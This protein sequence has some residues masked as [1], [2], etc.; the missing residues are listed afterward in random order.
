[1]GQSI[2][3]QSTKDKQPQT[4]F[5]TIFAF[6][7]N[8]ETLGGTAYLI[9]E[10][11]APWVQ[12]TD[13]EAD[14]GGHKGAN[15]LVDCPALTDFHREF[16]HSKGGI[17]TLFITH[18]GG[19]A[20]VKEFQREFNAQ[21]LIQEQEAYLLPGVE[22]VVFHRD[23]TLSSTSK[24]IWNPGHSPGSASLYYSNYGGVLFT[25]RHLVPDRNGAP[26]PLRLSKTFHWPRQL[27]YAQQLLSDFTADDLSYICP[28]A[29]TG[30]LRGD[31]TIK[32]AYQQL[33]S[34]NWQALAAAKP[35]I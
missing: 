35:V 27:R 19:M 26:V 11:L 16:I 9:L 29:S 12:T 32:A 5:D 20:R 34:T 25:G 15:I 10:D 22:T 18:R 6:A 33:E 1:M 2:S 4:V 24:V 28:G 31:K 13:K 17:Q 14:Q 21:V 3:T 23:R 30:Y 7:P 8:R